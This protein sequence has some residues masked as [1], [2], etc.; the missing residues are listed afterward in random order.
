MSL[1]AWNSPMGATLPLPASETSAHRMARS[2]R[3]ALGYCFADTQNDWARGNRWAAFDKARDA[4]RLGVRAIEATGGS[5]AVAAMVERL[6]VIVSPIGEDVDS[7]DN[8]ADV[9]VELNALEVSARD[10]SET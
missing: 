6:E 5:R 2:S 1:W 9:P 10:A 7:F 4:R 8:P 3:T